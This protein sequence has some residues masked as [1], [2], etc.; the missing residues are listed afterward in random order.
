[1]SSEREVLSFIRRLERLLGDGELEGARAVAEGVARMGS[2]VAVRKLA[3]ATAVGSQSAAEVTVSAAARADIRTAHRWYVVL[4]A[5]AR[6][7]IAPQ[8]TVRVSILALAVR[9]LEEELERSHLAA[10]AVP[11]LIRLAVDNL[12]DEASQLIAEQTLDFISTWH[13]ELADFACPNVWTSMLTDRIEQRLKR[14][15]DPVLRREWRNG[16]AQFRKLVRRTKYTEGSLATEISAVT[17]ALFSRRSGSRQVV[18]GIHVF[19]RYMLSILTALSSDERSGLTVALRVESPSRALVWGELATLVDR[20]QRF[21]Q[22]LADELAPHSSK[23]LEFLPPYSTPG[24]WTIVLKA[25]SSEERSSAI[26]NGLRNEHVKARWSEA[27]QEL[28]PATRVHA[29]LL[30]A[31]ALEAVALHDEAGNRKHSADVAPRVMS[32]DV[33]QADD[34]T[35]VWTLMKIIGTHSGDLRKIRSRFLAK[36]EITPRQFSYYFRAASIL[37]LVSERG[38]VTSIGRIVATSR[39]ETAM[40]IMESQFLA[41]DVG[42][43]WVLWSHASTV[44]ALK[45][46]TAERFL[47]ACV[48]SLSGSTRQRRAETLRSWLDTFTAE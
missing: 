34:L 3:L 14:V 16:T 11:G 41:S 32:R 31:R 24:S 45:P 10:F 22:E 48:P 38:H 39:C 29:S 40:Q 46:E 19:E 33:P 15:D 8:S 35:R 6:E 13:E 9:A 7:H 18:Q 1:M 20:V 44:A 47:G 37:H 27:I 17:K 28:P 25:R 12:A 2:L 5:L 23:P 36:S 42:S 26:L 21:L 43:A 30:G 4:A